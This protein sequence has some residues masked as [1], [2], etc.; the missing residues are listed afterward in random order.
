MKI[1]F[2][3]VTLALLSFSVQAQDHSNY[4]EG[5]EGCPSIGNEL[6]TELKNAMLTHTHID[7]DFVVAW[8][9]C[10]K[11]LAVPD[12]DRVAYENAIKKLK[13]H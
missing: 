10:Q 11:H 6:S 2:V 12:A 9:A 8:N 3:A 5:W 4:D 13:G 1:L 7:A